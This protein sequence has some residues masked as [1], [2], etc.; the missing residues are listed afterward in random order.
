M[1][2]LMA[3]VFLDKPEVLANLGRVLGV[4]EAAE[5]PPSLFVLMGDFSSTA[6]G[7]ASHN[8]AASRGSH[9]AR[10]LPHPRISQRAKLGRGTSSELTICVVRLACRVV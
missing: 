8:L 1:W 6:F 5:T 9:C 2:V 7:P 4:F 3:D 10:G